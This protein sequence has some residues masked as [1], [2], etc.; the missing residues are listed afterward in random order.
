MSKAVVNYELIADDLSRAG[1]PVR[2]WNEVWDGARWWLAANACAYVAIQNGPRLATP[3]P[4]PRAASFLSAPSEWRDS[5]QVGALREFIAGARKCAF[6]CDGR[7]TCAKCDEQPE[8]CP[9][10]SY[11]IVII[12][13]R[14]FNA[15]RIAE[16]LRY[17][18]DE[19]A[20]VSLTVMAAAHGGYVLRIQSGAGDL[21]AIV[22]SLNER[23]SGHLPMR[24]DWASA[25]AIREFPA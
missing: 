17:P 1:S 25:K 3:P 16:V 13:G 5:C 15:Q 21:L 11:A 6:C 10:C 9:A 24:G 14:K 2:A 20:A 18:D 7:C 23:A 4:K 8:P 19:S 12:G 22:M